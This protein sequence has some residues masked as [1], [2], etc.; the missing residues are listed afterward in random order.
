M[1][2][3]TANLYHPAL[4]ENLVKMNICSG[5][6]TALI[7]CLVE[8]IRGFLFPILFLSPPLLLLKLAG[9]RADTADRKGA[10][11]PNLIARYMTFSMSSEA[12]LPDANSFSESS[13]SVSVEADVEEEFGL[14]T[15]DEQ[16]F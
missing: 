6:E 8:I 16:L 1:V 10:G 9:A 11:F 4:D 15:D 7:F 13:Y 3:L 12:L 2:S 14:N 5:E